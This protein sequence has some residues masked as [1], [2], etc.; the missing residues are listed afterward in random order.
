MDDDPCFGVDELAVQRGKSRPTRLMSRRGSSYRPSRRRCCRIL[1]RQ[2]PIVRATRRPVR[3]CPR[4]RA[5]GRASVRV[6]QAMSCWL[7][8]MSWLRLMSYEWMLESVSVVEVVQATKCS[9]PL[10]QQLV[11]HPAVARSSGPRRERHRTTG[12]Q[13]L[14]RWITRPWHHLDSLLAADE[15]HVELGVVEDAE[16]PFWPLER[17]GRTREV[18]SLKSLVKLM[19]QL[20]SNTLQSPP[21]RWIAILRQHSDDL[22]TRIASDQLRRSCSAGTR[23]SPL[24]PSPPLQSPN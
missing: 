1:L 13:S 20:L 23:Y 5:K 19:T 8:R 24:R 11:L 7:R 18:E 17:V 6:Q 10:Q 2:Y 15:L 21:Q 4:H 22:Y 3:R 12:R 9:D 16:T 14:Q